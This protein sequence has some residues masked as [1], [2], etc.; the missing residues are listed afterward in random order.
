MLYKMPCVGQA[1]A[2]IEYHLFSASFDWSARYS[3]SSTTSGRWRMSNLSLISD[4]QKSH[5]SIDCFLTYTGWPLIQRNARTTVVRFKSRATAI[6]FGFIFS[7]SR[8][9]AFSANVM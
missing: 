6:L 1:S 8:R 5:G 2:A 4:S 7:S 3:L 9:K